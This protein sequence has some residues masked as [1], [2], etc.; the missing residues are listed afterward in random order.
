MG[1]RL[2]SSVALLASSRLGS[3]RLGAARLGA[4][5]EGEGKERSGAADAEQSRI[6]T[7]QVGSGFGIGAS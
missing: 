6:A 2:R 1:S 5:R 7:R 4:E 3:A